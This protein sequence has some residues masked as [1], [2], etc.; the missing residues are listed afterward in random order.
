MLQIRSVQKPTERQFN[1]SKQPLSR[2]DIF[3]FKQVFAHWAFFVFVLAFTG[4]LVFK[5]RSRQCY[6]ICDILYFIYIY[7]CDSQREKT[8]LKIFRP[9]AF[10][11]YLCKTLFTIFLI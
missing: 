8:F 4:N 7:T 3:D 5:W 11:S 2:V 6:F 9:D 10:F 1:K